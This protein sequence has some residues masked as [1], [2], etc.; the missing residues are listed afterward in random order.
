M[1]QPE[2][3]EYLLSLR[4]QGVR[5]VSILKQYDIASST[6]YYWLSRYSG[7]DTYSNLSRAPKQTESKVTE[8]I[9]AEVIQTHKTYPI[10]PFLHEGGFR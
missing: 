10:A 1:T 3:I 4:E 8:A 9:K 2:K 7:Y 6:F 5:V